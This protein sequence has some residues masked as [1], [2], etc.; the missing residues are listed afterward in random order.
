MKFL[1]VF[2][3]LLFISHISFAQNVL[4]LMN[5]ADLFFET[6]NQ[7]KFDEAHGFF[8]ESVKARISVDELK[9]FWLKL[10]NSLGTY[11]SVDGAKSSVQGEYFQV[12]LT[13]GFTKGSQPFTFM[14]NKT[15]K[16]VGFFVSPKATE[17]EYALP[18]Y[19]DTTLYTVKEIKIKF[20]EGEMAGILTSP[21][22]VFNFPLVIMVHGSNRG[23]K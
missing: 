9:L 19:A 1:K 6:M 7:G 10:E 17:S 12:I 23:V 14:F 20:A 15:E 3:V 16:L 8:D 22:K 18:A 13:C 5:R 2:I 21:K 4:S 11:Q